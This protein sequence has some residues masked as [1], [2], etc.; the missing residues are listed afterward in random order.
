[1]FISISF[2]HIQQWN[3]LLPWPMHVVVVV[4]V[5]VVVFTIVYF[6]PS[7]YFYAK[8]IDIGITRL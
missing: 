2:I 4:V 8:S 3:I 7:S 5:V 1:M 6:A